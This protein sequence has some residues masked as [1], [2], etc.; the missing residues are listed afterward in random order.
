MV[1][2]PT[3][4]PLLGAD[5]F[6]KATLDTALRSALGVS[7][8]TPLTIHAVRPWTMA[9]RV[10]TDWAPSNRLLLAGDAAHQVPPAGGLGLNLGVGDAGA[11]AWRLAAVLRGTPSSSALASYTA[12]RRAVAT[13]AAAL[14]VANWKAAL[15]VPRALGLDDRA[16]SAASRAAAAAASSGL[17]PEAA[18]RAGLAAVLAAGRALGA[19]AGGAP[20]AALRAARSARHAV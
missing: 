15:A 18:A 16:A 1:Q 14:S 3:F 2:L 10:A 17:V 9:A 12:E 8:S 11:L 19:S 6:R 7:S 5:A 13:A 20:G 4:P